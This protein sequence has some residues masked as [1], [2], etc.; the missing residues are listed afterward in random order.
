MEMIM[1]FANDK[2]QETLCWHFLEDI[3][4]SVTPKEML[5]MGDWV[6]NISQKGYK[7][8]STA[9]K[10]SYAILASNAL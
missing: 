8:I 4:E 5:D 2:L 3:K 7:A 9:S 10:E 1:S 6:A